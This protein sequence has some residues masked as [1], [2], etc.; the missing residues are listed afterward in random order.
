MKNFLADTGASFV[1]LLGGIF[2]GMKS[3]LT[4]KQD[5]PISSLVYGMLSVWF[6]G[7]VLS[8]IHTICQDRKRK[9]GP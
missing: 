7:S 4:F 8:E 3:F 5:E 1:V 2:F 9:G 6:I